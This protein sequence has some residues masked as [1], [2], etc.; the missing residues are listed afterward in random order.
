MRRRPLFVLLTSLG[1]LVG[2]ASVLG[3]FDVEA[4]GSSPDASSSG[5]TSSSGNVGEAG[6]EG[7]GS[8]SGKE[9]G[10]ADVAP[11]GLQVAT[12]TSATCAT[13]QYASG[14]KVTYCWGAQG[15]KYPANTVGTQSIADANVDGFY[16]PRLPT[17]DVKYLTFSYLTGA[18]TGEWFVGRG[19]DGQTTATYAWGSN[20]TGETAAGNLSSTMPNVL[21]L[22]TSLLQFDTIYAAPNHGC[23]VQNNNFFCWGNNT[24]CEIRSG[25]SAT[26][27]T[28]ETPILADK[29]SRV[30]ED[31]GPHASS[32]GGPV[33]RMAGGAD[34]SCRQVKAGSAGPD[35]LEDVSCWGSNLFGQIDA[36]GGA[37]I[38]APTVVTQV[39][40]GSAELAAGENHTCVINDVSKITCWGRNDS[41]Q[42]NPA[43]KSQKSKPNEVNNLP[44]L[45]ST[46]R[47]AGDL[48]CVVAKP[49][50]QP[51][52]AWCWGNGPKARIAGEEDAPV[53][54]VAG[55]QDVTELAIGRS[56]ACAVARK[57]GA[58]ASDLPHVYCWGT[59]DFKRVD[60]RQPPNAPPILQPIQIQFPPEPAN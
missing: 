33:V 37:F 47:A 12:S 4:T 29:N 32:K 20:D 34:H 58:T 19:S 9:G 21:K 55:I 31:E 7:G 52:R 28:T 36:A 13:V 48:S 10:V 27:N 22:N 60:P 41:G 50:G 16:R 18:G 2:C 40:R 17:A 6:S 15:A 3:D 53:G 45:L 1:T 8:D 43:N 38:D 26:C 35:T 39:R 23:M 59:N 42:S 51:S 54:K 25:A 30:V 44:G 57:E 46:L 56:H 14:K 49:I 11:T 5:N 24:N